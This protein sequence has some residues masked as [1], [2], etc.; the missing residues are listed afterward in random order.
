M[1]SVKAEPTAAVARLGC[2]LTTFVP[3]HPLAGRERS[4][5]AAARADLFPGRPWALCSGPE[6]SAEPVRPR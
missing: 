2:D 3:G 1:A 5:P 4:G 6:T